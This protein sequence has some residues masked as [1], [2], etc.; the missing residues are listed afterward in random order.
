MTKK[1]FIEMALT[2]V[3]IQAGIKTILEDEEK[4]KQI[5]KICLN[6]I[7]NL[8]YAQNSRFNIETFK[9]FIATQGGTI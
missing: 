3:K 8:C 6:E 9:H 2:I 1:D 7:I 4:I 5:N